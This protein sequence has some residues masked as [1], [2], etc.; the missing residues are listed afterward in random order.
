MS[1]PYKILGVKKTDSKKNIIKAYRKMAKKWHPDKHLNNKDQAEDK[2]KEIS[3]AYQQIINPER[4]CFNDGVFT[5]KFDEEKINKFTENIFEKGKQFSDWF[6]KLKKMDLGNLTDNFLKEAVKYKGFY[7]DVT[8][9]NTSLKKTEDIILNLIV[10]LEDIFNNVE[11][12]LNIKHKRKCKTCIGIGFTMKGICDECHG[13]KYKEYNKEIK[14]YSS[15]KYL[16]L[17]EQSNEEEDYIPGDIIININPKDNNNFCII[18][19]YDILYQIN[20][21]KNEFKYLNNKIYKINKKN[22]IK[23]KK[24]KIP[25][26]GLLDINKQRGNL[27]IQPI[28]SFKSNYLNINDSLTIEQN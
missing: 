21:E 20:L 11:K 14:F 24:Y 4:M 5:P 2:F 6:V 27:Y 13:N 22:I 7:N 1:N 12:T 8:K 19:N 16:I 10:K 9:N 17:K 28:E 18:H 25:E 23:N 3:K 15:Q 26:L